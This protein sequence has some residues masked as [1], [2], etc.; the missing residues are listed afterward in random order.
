MRCQRR[1]FYIGDNRFQVTW[2]GH[3]GKIIGFSV[4]GSP[5]KYKPSGFLYLH[6]LTILSLS[7]VPV[8]EEFDFCLNESVSG[9]SRQRLSWHSS[10]AGLNRCRTGRMRSV[11]LCLYSYTTQVYMPEGQ[12]HS[13]QKNIDSPDKPT[14]SQ[15]AKAIVQW[16]IF[17]WI[18]HSACGLHGENLSW[19]RKLK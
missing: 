5:C 8:A 11:Q 13:L 16:W 9:H 7:L 14:G 10:G 3:W 4:A 6:C 1:A 12:L 19:V 2:Q 15:A 17:F 18:R